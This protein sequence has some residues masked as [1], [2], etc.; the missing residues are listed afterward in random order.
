MSCW[1]T[2]KK[3]G[4]KM[5]GGKLVND[6]RPKSESVELGED[7]SGTTATTPQMTNAMKQRATLDMKISQLRKQA[8][9]KDQSE[10]K[11]MKESEDKL[12]DQRMERGGVDGNVRY[13]KAPKS[14]PKSAKKKYDGMSALDFVKADL[15][16]KYG[17]GAIHSKKK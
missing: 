2:H 7:L 14:S 12:R 9:Q 10:K 4:M 1:K 3:V 8:L 13:D 5:K 15:T 16:K 6:C 17:K 11:P